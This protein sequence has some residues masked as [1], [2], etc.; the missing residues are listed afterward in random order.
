MILL[1][2]TL[3][4][5][6]SVGWVLFRFYAVIIQYSTQQVGWSLSAMKTYPV[7]SVQKNMDHLIEMILF[8]IIIWR[9]Y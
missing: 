1:L 4:V 3:A 8:I 6:F 5:A 2:L 7:T 9:L